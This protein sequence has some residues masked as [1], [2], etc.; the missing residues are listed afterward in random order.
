M[1]LPHVRYPFL[2]VVLLFPL[3]CT[4]CHFHLYQSRWN[5]FTITCTSKMDRLISLKFNWLGVKLWRLS[6]PLIFW[7]VC[8]L[9]TFQVVQVISREKAFLLKHKTLCYLA[10]YFYYT[11]FWKSPEKVAHKWKTCLLILEDGLADYGSGS[12]AVKIHPQ[13]LEQ[14]LAYLLND[15]AYLILD[16]GKSNLPKQ[17]QFTRFFFNTWTTPNLLQDYVNGFPPN[18]AHL[19][20]AF[21]VIR[22]TCMKCLYSVQH[23]ASDNYY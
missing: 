5:W 6:V 19:F 18:V 22:H 13:H 1:W 7:A 14:F 4:C 8:I 9:G 23:T 16:L 15:L 17:S 21:I 20:F 3:H 12:L 2:R 10:T 11:V